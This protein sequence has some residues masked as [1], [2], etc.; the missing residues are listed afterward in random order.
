MNRN[1]KVAILDS[2]KR[3]WQV[4]KE[5]PNISDSKL[6]K[7]V[8]GYILPTEEEMNRLAQVLGR[9]PEELF[10]ET[11]GKESKDAKL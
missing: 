6:S 3:N 9:E 8:N 1:L 7:I 4:A 5:T 10:P 11:F 2:G